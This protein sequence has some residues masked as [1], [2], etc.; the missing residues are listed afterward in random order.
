VDPVIMAV[1]PVKFVVVG[2]KRGEVRNWDLRKR[3]R[4]LEVG[5][6]SSRDADMVELE[7]RWLMEVQ[8][9]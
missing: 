4:E 7:L 5:W 6:P 3:E 2:G 8:R 9:H 1:W